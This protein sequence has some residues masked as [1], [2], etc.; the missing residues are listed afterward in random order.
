MACSSSPFSWPSACKCSSATGWGNLMW[1]AATNSTTPCKPA[2]SCSLN[3]NKSAMEKAITA[4]TGEYTHVALVERD[5]A[6]IITR[7]KSLVGKSYDIVFL[8]D[9]DA[10]YCSELIQVAF[11]DIFPSKPMNW[12]DAEGN[13]PEYWIKHFEELGAPVPEGVPGTNPT[14]MS[15]SP[16][17]KRLK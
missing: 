15:R 4:S 3:E 10:Y 16:L 11:G 17:L 9:N 5:S 2:I 13:L 12:R 6:M 14:D 1:F 8:P 7:T